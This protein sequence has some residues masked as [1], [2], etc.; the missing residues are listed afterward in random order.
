MSDGYQ[1]RIATSSI[2]EGLDF[3]C[4]LLVGA[5]QN[6]AADPARDARELLS[7]LAQYIQLRYVGELRLA[8]EELT[9]LAADLDTNLKD[10][11][12][13]QAQMKWVQDSLGHEAI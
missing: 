11:A 1:Q 9:A 4:N 3:A 2:E 8:F 12:Q 13:F 10:P 5:I 7:S 6:A